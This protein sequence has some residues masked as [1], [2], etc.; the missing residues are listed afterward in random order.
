VGKQGDKAWEERGPTIANP[1]KKEPQ[2][3]F[4]EKVIGGKKVGKREDSKPKIESVGVNWV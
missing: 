3:N 4:W 2:S 1:G